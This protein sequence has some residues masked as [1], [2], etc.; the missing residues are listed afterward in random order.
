LPA[1]E[2]QPAQLRSSR[3]LTVFITVA[4]FAL[5]LGILTYGISKLTNF[6][7]QVSPWTYAHPLIQ[8]SGA[9]LTW[10]F[11]GYQ[12]WFQFLLGLCETVPGLLLLNR[13]TW[14][15]G[16]LLLFPVLLNVVLINFAL[17]LWHDTKIISSVL[18]LL[19][20]FLLACDLRRYRTILA[21]LLPPPSPFRN[22]R[23]R[24]TAIAAAILVSV[25]AMG[26]FWV[27]GEMPANR[28]M[29]EI[30]DFV[31]IRQI[32]GAGTWAVDRVTVSG[33]EITGAPDRRLYFDIFKRCGYK[34]GLD[35]SLGTFKATRIAHSVSISGVA[36]GGDSSP[37]SATYT[38]QGK[39]L[40]IEGQR[41]GQAVEIVLH[42]LNWG[43]MLPYGP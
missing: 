16:A 10:A 39:V 43:P 15:L 27:F 9:M 20:V 36:L 12:P 6:Q 13:R 1:V 31:G 30:S 2:T 34:S 32:N 26:A 18:L 42:R 25:L 4:R 3:V 23:V 19:N 28:D 24:A 33:H 17:D 37:I 22:H 40:R 11:L 14:R 21:I 7:F 38:L 8:T 29:D 5:G 41:N 35:E